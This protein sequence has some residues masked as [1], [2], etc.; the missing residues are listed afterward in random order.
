MLGVLGAN[1]YPIFIVPAIAWF[2][3]MVAAFTAA[4]EIFTVALY[5][6]ATTGEP[7]NGYDAATLGTALRRR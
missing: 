5:R 7:P 1:G 4:R 3:T 2:A 6:Y